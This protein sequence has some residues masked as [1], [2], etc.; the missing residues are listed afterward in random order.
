MGEELVGPE[1]FD[2]DYLWF[3]D[4]M[5]E[6]GSDAQVELIRGLL[7]LPSGCEVLD[8][9][10]GHGRI[11]NRVAGGG[12]RVAG[13]DSSRL[14]LDLARERAAAAGVSV[15]YVEGDLREM[16]FEGRFDAAINWFTSFGYF[17][18]EGNRRVLEGFRR[19]LKPGGVLLLEQA[20]R[21]FLLANMP[22]SGQAVWMAERGD[23]LMID[24]VTFDPLLGRSHT[25]RIIVR[26]GRVRRAEFSLAQ[27][28]AA[29]LAGML[30]DAGFADVRALD[31]AG[32]P[33][34]QRSRR[35]L[36]LA[37]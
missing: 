27:P 31:E 32:R 18:D 17:D 28:T 4:D 7:D 2:E 29:D 3:Y 37:R 22:A 8:A 15:E 5:L 1:L 10:C 20:S 23:D 35:L 30:R 26:D 11:A 19:A 16:P 6:Q 24:K 21:D 34:T 9:P 13:L 33:F 14:F 25:E 36:M 12:W